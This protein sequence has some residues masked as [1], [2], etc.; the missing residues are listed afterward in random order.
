MDKADHFVC[1]PL[2]VNIR[3]YPFSLN[4]LSSSAIVGEIYNQGGR[5]DFVCHGYMYTHCPSLLAYLR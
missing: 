4:L 1:A 5:F 2:L 3:A